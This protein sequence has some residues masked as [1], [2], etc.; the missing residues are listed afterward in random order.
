M[1]RIAWGKSGSRFF[2]S[3]LDRGVLYIK[4]LSSVLSSTPLVV[5]AGNKTFAYSGNLPRE[6]EI[7]RFVKAAHPDHLDT[8]YMSGTIVAL[9]SGTVTINVTEF[10]PDPSISLSYNPWL[11]ALLD[12][13]ISWNGLTAV[14]ESGSS[15]S[16]A[17]YLD[18]RPYLNFPMPKEFSATV[19]AYTY[20]DEFSAMQGLVE[21]ADGM[22]LD[23]Q[24]GDSFGLSY[25]TLIGNDLDPELGYKIHLIYNATVVPPSISRQTKTNEINP[26]EF[27]WE[28][29]AVPMM[30]EG[31]RPTAHI[32]IDTRHMDSL[33]LSQLEDMLYGSDTV[34][35]HLPDPQTIFDLLTYGEGIIITDNG[36]GTWSA[37]G[38][39]HNIYMIGD[40]IF[41]IDNIDAIDHGDGSYTISSTP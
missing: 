35:A 4:N 28:I 29:Q 18:G 6:F 3:G 32:E 41:Q 12:T 15:G 7:G 34:P 20:P 2:E 37:Q 31:Y 30:I 11:I 36:D 9:G 25:R 24:Q 1:P 26:T 14:D 16:R 19:K 17:Y 23:S 10:K 22:Y 27:S 21:A 38:S 5:E 40:G 33:R 13:A 39:Y 8:L